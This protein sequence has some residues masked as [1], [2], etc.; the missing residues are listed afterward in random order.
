MKLNKFTIKIKL[1]LPVVKTKRDKKN[2]KILLLII[3]SNYNCVISKWYQTKVKPIKLH[4]AN[5]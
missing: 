1:K 4:L 3:I 2:L 5:K